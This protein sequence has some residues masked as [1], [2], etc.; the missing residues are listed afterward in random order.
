ML[1][2]SFEPTVRNDHQGEF[3]S[4]LHLLGLDKQ[5]FKVQ[6]SWRHTH[7]HTVTHTGACRRPLLVQSDTASVSDSSQSASVLSVKFG[8]YGTEGSPAPEEV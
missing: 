6:T 1:K 8:T 2:L 3:D 4:I 5:S 7:T